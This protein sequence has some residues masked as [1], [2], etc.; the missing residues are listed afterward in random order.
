MFFFGLLLT[1]TQNIK[2]KHLFGGFTSSYYIFEKRERNQ[3]KTDHI[4]LRHQHQTTHKKTEWAQ[5]PL[6]HYIFLYKKKFAIHHTQT[7]KHTQK[8]NFGQHK[9]K[10][11]HSL[12]YL[13]PPPRPLKSC[14]LQ[15]WTTF[16]QEPP[17]LKLEKKQTKQRTTTQQGINMSIENGEAKKE[18]LFDY[19]EE[20]LLEE[21]VLTHYQILGIEEHT[22]TDHVKKAY[23]KASL[24]CVLIYLIL[25]SHPCTCILLFFLA[26]IS[27]PIIYSY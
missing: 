16:Y 25:I 24:K 18:N 10:R 20:Q 1:V 17:F 6:G 14:I 5:P 22:S 21:N 15:P 3:Q 26:H 9:N 7:N 4:Y 2:K 11:R 23:R 27:T 19:T 12:F 8:E 13:P